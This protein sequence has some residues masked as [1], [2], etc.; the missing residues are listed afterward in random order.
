M[1]GADVAPRA[2]YIRVPLLAVEK[3]GNAG[4]VES[5]QFW[6]AQP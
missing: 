3:D 6:G 5:S 1:P 4:L 2:G